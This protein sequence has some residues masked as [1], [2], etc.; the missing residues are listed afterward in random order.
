MYDSEL[1]RWYKYWNMHYLLYSNTDERCISWEKLVYFYIFMNFICHICIIFKKYFY[2]FLFL[3][4]DGSFLSG[5]G[6]HGCYVTT[7]CLSC[8]IRCFYYWNASL[9]W[10]TQKWS[11][12]YICHRLWVTIATKYCQILVKPALCDGWQVINWAVIVINHH[13]FSCQ[14]TVLRERARFVSLLV[15][16]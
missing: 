1:A 11:H 8:E 9:F 14:V 10:N 4:R 5:W 7:K 12:L 6:I 2:Y 15:L 16:P 3:W 13:S